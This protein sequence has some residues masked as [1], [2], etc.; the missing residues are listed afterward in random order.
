MTPYLDLADESLAGRFSH[1]LTVTTKAFLSKLYRMVQC[2]VPSIWL[3]SV[4]G[5]NT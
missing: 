1:R 5:S 4:D 3:D 2:N